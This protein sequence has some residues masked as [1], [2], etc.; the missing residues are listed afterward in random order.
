MKKLL[1]KLLGHK[2]KIVDKE[3]YCVFIC[4]RCENYKLKIKK[5]WLKK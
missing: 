5:G 3:G 4:V 2:Y 1:C